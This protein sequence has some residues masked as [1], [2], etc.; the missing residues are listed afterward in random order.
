M[1]DD[2]KQTDKLL[3]QIVMDMRMAAMLID[4]LNNEGYNANFVLSESKLVC[5]QNHH[6]YFTWD[7]KVDQVYRID[8]EETG[9]NGLY[10]YAIRLPDEDLRGVYLIQTKSTLS[11]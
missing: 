7:M 1:N 11:K 5:L 10:I 4:R 3:D 6:T 2:L 8:D 9:I